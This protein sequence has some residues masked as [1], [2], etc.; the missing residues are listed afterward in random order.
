MLPFLRT[1]HSVQNPH[2]IYHPDSQKEGR[3][4]PA[5]VII[6]S[7]PHA[8][9]QGG[10][11]LVP[12]NTMLPKGVWYPSEVHHVTMGT[13][14]YSHHATSSVGVPSHTASYTVA[15][16]ATRNAFVHYGAPTLQSVQGGPSYGIPGDTHRMPAPAQYV[17][18]YGA[19]SQAMHNMQFQYAMSVPPYPQHSLSM[20]S[21]PVTPEYLQYPG[22]GSPQMIPTHY[23]YSS[24]YHTG[25]V[26][27]PRQMQVAYVPDQH[28]LD[29][30][31]PVGKWIVWV[32]VFFP[33]PKS[34][35]FLVFLYVICYLISDPAILFYRLYRVIFVDLIVLYCRVHRDFVFLDPQLLWRLTEP[36][37]PTFLFGFLSDFFVVSPDGD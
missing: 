23:A 37:D 6:A 33:G 8:I 35:L 32:M 13:P 16:D 27:V 18:N 22:Y 29:P 25:E 24:V 11:S 2:D 9:H 30:N 14:G 34:D 21:S 26:P 31:R 4:D 1:N 20:P 15:T 17:A 12:I 7:D 28:A 3:V 10:F 5:A 19:V 36:H